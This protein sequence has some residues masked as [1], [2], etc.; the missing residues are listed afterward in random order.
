[1]IAA[2]LARTVGTM[3]VI[4]RCLIEKFLT[5]SQ[6][7]LSRRGGR[8][9]RR[10]NTFRMS[11]LQSAID[12]I[13]RDVVETLALVLLRQALPVQLCRL[14]QAQRT[15]HVGTGKGKGI[16]DTPVHMALSRQ[17]DNAVHLML[18]H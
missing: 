12:L 15:H 10:L 18:L 16:L 1:M 13:G 8:G 9:E 4:F 7:M 14:Q 3:R 2:R 17:M 5:I 6:M 11:Q